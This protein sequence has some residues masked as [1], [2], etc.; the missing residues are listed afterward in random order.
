MIPSKGRILQIQH[1]SVNDGSGIR[2]IVFFAGCPLRCRWC[3]NPEGF[4]SSRRILYIASRCRKCGRCQAVCPV[5]AGMDLS[6]RE[7]RSRCIGCGRCVK[8]CLF[9]ARKSS[10]TEMTVEEILDSL[11]NQRIFLFNSGGGITYSG[12]E[13]TLQAPFLRELSKAV[14]DAGL[15]QAMETSGCFS[16]PEVQDILERMDL[17]FMDIK[18]WDSEKHARYTGVSNEKILDNIARIGARRKGLVVRVPVIMGVNGDDE[19]IRHTASFV[20]KYLKDPMMELLPY[21]S[22]GAGK[23]EQ[24]GLPYDET[25][26]RRPSEEEMNHLSH[27]VEEEGVRLVSFR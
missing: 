5:Q 13:C 19:N 22:Y 6:V 26:F 2:T 1:Y 3:A 27:V 21:H 14:Y 10:M 7:N 18:L 4:T 8:A 9:G 15:D 12:G 20:R 23:Y 16:L 17:L 25:G 24:L 11:E